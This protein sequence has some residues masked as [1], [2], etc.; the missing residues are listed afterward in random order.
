VSVSTHAEVVE[1]AAKI[2]YDKERACVHQEV[3]QQVRGGSPS[4][5]AIDGSLNLCSRLLLM[6]GIGE[7]PLGIDGSNTIRWDQG[8]LR[9]FAEKYFGPGTGIK[10]QPDNLQIGK[11]F[12]A[13]NLKKIGGMRIEWTR[14]LADHLRL[15]DDDKTVSIFD[16]VAFLKFQ[17]KCVPLIQ[18]LR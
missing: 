5:D 14:N 1:I 13:L 7:P 3:L 12:T 4:A 17:T 9:E 10:L 2:H 8:T 15:V 18:R 6:M 11:I 16:C